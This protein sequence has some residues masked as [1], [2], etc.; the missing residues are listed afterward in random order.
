M[1]VI[2]IGICL[3]HSFDLGVFQMGRSY[4][5]SAEFIPLFGPLAE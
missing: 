1:L 4:G 2:L 5:W 3:V